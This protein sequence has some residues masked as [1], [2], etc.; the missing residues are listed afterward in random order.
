MIS[1]TFDFFLSFVFH[2]IYYKAAHIYIF[3]EDK[4]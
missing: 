4:T 3:I 2:E 1:M